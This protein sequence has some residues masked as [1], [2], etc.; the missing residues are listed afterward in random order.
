[1]GWEGAYEV[2][3][4]GRIRRLNPCRT[5]SPSA[6]T[7]GHLALRLWSDGTPTNA[8]LHRLVCEAFHGPPPEGKPW[9]LHKDDDKSNNTPENLYWGTRRDNQRDAVRNLRHVNSKKKEC[10]RGHALTGDN[11]YVTKSGRRECRTCG[12]RT[13]SQWKKNRGP[14]DLSDNSTIHGTETGYFIYKCKCPPCAQAGST[15]GKRHRSRRNAKGLQ[16]GDPAH[17]TSKGYKTWGCKCSRCRAWNSAYE[18]KR[19]ERLKSD[20]S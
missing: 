9:A 1:M 18:A 4:L 14:E 12:R 15:A 17:G 13:R 7:S 16:P 6:N 2:S 8:L 20:K 5:L 3:S 19:K 10:I 11:L